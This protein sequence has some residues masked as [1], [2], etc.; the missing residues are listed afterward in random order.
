M[1]KLGLVVL[2]L[3][4]LICLLTTLMLIPEIIFVS[5]VLGLAGSFSVVFI[6]T[7]FAESDDL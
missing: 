1:K 3:V 6:L 2:W 4:G 7:K 5:F